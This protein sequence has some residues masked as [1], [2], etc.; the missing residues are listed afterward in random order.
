M[1]SFGS[2]FFASDEPA[3]ERV[4]R[5]AI[6]MN[7]WHGCEGSNRANLARR[8]S[9]LLEN[10]GETSAAPVPFAVLLRRRNNKR[11]AMATTKKTAAK[12]KVRVASIPIVVYRPSGSFSAPVG[13]TFAILPGG[14]L[15][16]QHSTTG[17]LFT[18]AFAPGDWTSVNQK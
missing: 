10:C 12:K 5:Q 4:S 11:I 9:S 18:H 6:P 13:S 17:N 14:A 2:P 15:V 3:L 7:C 1:G 16:L 8:R